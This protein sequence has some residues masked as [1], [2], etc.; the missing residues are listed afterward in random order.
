MRAV[1][2]IVTIIAGVTA[3]FKFFVLN[4]VIGPKL[5]QRRIRNLEDENR[6][7]DQ[8]LDDLLAKDRE[9]RRSK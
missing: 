3:I 6:L 9:R 8:Q 7:Y 1:A 5:R 2:E 4:R